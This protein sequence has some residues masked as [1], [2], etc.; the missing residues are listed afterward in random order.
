MKGERAFIDGL[1]A[2]ATHPAAR[3]LQDDCAVLELGSETLVLTHDMMVGGV[4]FLADADMADVAWKL[5]ASNLSD[6]AA[7]GAEPLGVL[8]GH[9]LG[10]EED[11]KRFVKGLGEAL[12]HYGVAL[13]GGDTSAGGPPRCYGLTA[14][15]RATCSPVP[16]RTGAQVDDSIYLVGTLGGAMQGFQ[17]LTSRSGADATAFLRPIPRLAEGRALAPCVTSMMDVSD[18][19]LLDAS[20][21]ARASNV[22]M[23]IESHLVPLTSPEINRQA[24]MRWGEDYALLFT[25]PKGVNLPV[26]ATRIG[27]VRPAVDAPVRLDNLP[28][29]EEDGLG[30]EHG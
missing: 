18:G 9:M 17:A 2:L 1:R 28:L 4:H 27:T 11:D 20:R 14:F 26:P 25:A 30:Y 10:D 13:L 24:A 12:E 8:L 22:T 23:T 16:S 6:L 21:I 15:G 19:L 29:R 3:N 5:V 7:K